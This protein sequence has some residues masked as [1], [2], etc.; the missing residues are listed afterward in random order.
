MDRVLW[1]SIG[2]MLGANARYWLGIWAAQRWGTA[3]PWGTFL[4]NLSGSFLLGLFMTLVTGRYSVD[5]NWRL[6]VT[7]GF[8][9]AYTTF[10][11]FT[12][13]SINLFLK[14]QW[15]AGLLNVL[16]SAALG[17][18]AAGIGVYLGKVLS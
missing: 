13:E 5:P 6:L 8:L 11:T 17:L 12:Y 2:A 3:F 16:G 1:I 4:I 7:V 18:L 15:L 14:G 9:G 10:S